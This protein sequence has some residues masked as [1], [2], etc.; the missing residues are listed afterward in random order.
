LSKGDWEGHM[1]R[2]ALPPA[3]REALLRDPF[4]FR[5][6]QGESYRDVVERVGPAFDR[7]VARLA[8]QRVLFV[9]H[10]DVIRALLHHLLRF[11]P[12]KI[13]DLATAPCALTELA[14][15]GARIELMR[16]NDTSHL[17]G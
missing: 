3:E 4:G 11:D 8:G 12:M 9:L 1:P 13:G 10:G 14:H 15:Q 7:W 6:P 5:Y 17:E 16:F 2:D